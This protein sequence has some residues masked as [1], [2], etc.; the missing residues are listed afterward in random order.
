LTVSEVSRLIQGMLADNLP[1]PIRVVGEV[2]NF[3]SRTHWFFSLKDEAATLRA[4]CFASSARRVGFALKDGMQVVATGRLDYYDAGG[5]LQLYVERIEPVGL[6]ALDLRFRALCDELRRLRYFDEERKKPLPMIPR[7]VAVVT[8]RTGAALQDVIHTA[9]R[10]WDGCQ[11]LLLDVRVQG[12]TAAPEIAAAI[13][14]LSRHGQRLGI[15]A[16]IL[17]RGGGSIEDLW[18]FNERVVADAIYACAIPIVAAIG[19]ETDTTIAE[20]VADRRCATPTQAAMTL[21]PA[22][23]ALSQQV[24]QIEQRLTML[25][26]RYVRHERQRLDG[27]SRHPIFRR[28]GTIYK[29]I[30]ERLDRLTI[31][32]QAALPRAVRGARDRLTLLAPG[33]RDA[34]ARRLKGD[35]ERIESLARQ[36]EALGPMNVLRRG[37]TY[38]LGSDGHL[39]RSAT[40]AHAGERIATI[41]VDG[42]MHSRVEPPGR[43]GTGNREQGTAELP[44]PGPDGAIKPLAVKKRGGAK[45]PPEQGPGLFG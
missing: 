2:S 20:L 6:G 12:A 35:G 17:T 11:L 27:L 33:L 19:H 41:F 24:T 45:A 4:V 42:H 14:A 16:I 23:E 36:L 34:T 13:T 40:K 38:T 43:E 39:L 9:H 26:Q 31:D 8:S 37:Y 32:L 28:P 21:I 22:G 18:A 30:R 7:R 10:R 15:E 25:A 3:S 44:A 5:Q 1:A 29:P